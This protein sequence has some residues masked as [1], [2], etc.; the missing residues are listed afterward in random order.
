MIQS[1]QKEK[2]IHANGS[3]LQFLEEIKREAE[4]KGHKRKNL[5]FRCIPGPENKEGIKEKLEKAKEKHKGEIIHALPS[6]KEGGGLMKFVSI[7]EVYDITHLEKTNY[8]DIFEFKKG[9]LVGRYY[10][11]QK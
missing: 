8:Q 10:R 6:Y 9:G 5:V 11:D 4:Q 1:I 3:N 7:V 2:I